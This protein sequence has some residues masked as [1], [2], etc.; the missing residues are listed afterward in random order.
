MKKMYVNSGDNLFGDKK[1]TLSELAKFDVLMYK[2]SEC[3]KTIE[4]SLYEWIEKEYEKEYDILI[5]K[6][7]KEKQK[8]KI[9]DL[10]KIN[11]LHKDTNIYLKTL[12]DDVK[13]IKKIIKKIQCI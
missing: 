4:E 8:L 6:L 13:K 12:D 1:L 7:R 9:S 10:E 3:L 5:F 2:N 11:Q